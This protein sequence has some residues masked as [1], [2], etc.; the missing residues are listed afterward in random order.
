[1]SPAI[2]RFKASSVSAPLDE[3]SS[4]PA[5]GAVASRFESHPG[6]SRSEACASCPTDLGPS[7]A[8]PPR[9]VAGAAFA[10]STTRGCAPVATRSTAALTSLRSEDPSPPAQHRSLILS[11]CQQS[12][13]RNVLVDVLPMQTAA[14]KLNR[15][16]L[17]GRC[18]QESR[19]PRVGHAERPAVRQFDPH[20]IVVEP[21][22]CGRSIHSRLSRSAP[23]PHS[24]F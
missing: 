20:Q 12:S 24:P 13:D 8:T 5:R 11:T 1:M 14:T 3:A 2:S 17:F 7:D 18:V 15:L 9:A 6:C 16:A 10:V 23:S 4:G 22:R 21:N 19:K